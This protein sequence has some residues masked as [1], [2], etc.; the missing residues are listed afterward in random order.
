MDD[1]R[2][3]AADERV[4]AAREHL[5]TRLDVLEQRVVD[6]VDEAS[7]AVRGTAD[8]VQHLFDLPQHVRDHP[9]SS[10]GLAAATGFFAAF[11]MRRPTPKKAAPLPKPV[12]SDRR[13]ALA[14]LL[15]VARRE[16]TKLGEEAIV[17]GV[18]ALKQNLQDVA[19][20]IAKNHA[21]QSNGV[22]C[23]A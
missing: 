11:M 8:S 2:E 18:H 20:E 7:A 1:K 3:G 22:H 16:F 15:G 19:T 12:T 9:W 17:A 6:A 5:G 23:N 21:H 10:V 4:E 13:S 14:D